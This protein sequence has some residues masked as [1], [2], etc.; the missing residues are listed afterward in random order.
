MVAGELSPISTTSFSLTTS[1]AFTFF[2]L[3]PHSLVLATDTLKPYIIS[4][5][6]LLDYTVSAKP[7][8]AS[9]ALP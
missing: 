6:A 9:I 4:P 3:N 1:T 8:A 5:V 7:V 2:I